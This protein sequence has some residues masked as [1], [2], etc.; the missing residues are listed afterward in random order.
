MIV[1]YFGTDETAA[2]RALKFNS[3]KQRYQFYRSLDDI[4]MNIIEQSLFIILSDM[5][6]CQEDFNILCQ[7]GVNPIRIKFF[8]NIEW[9]LG[10]SFLG[11]Y[12]WFGRTY[13]RSCVYRNGEY[14]NKDYSG[15][16]QKDFIEIKNCWEKTINR[17]RKKES[18]PCDG[19]FLLKEHLWPRNVELKSL[20]LYG[21]FKGESCNF[22]CIYCDATD[23]LKMAKSKNNITMLD[24]IEAFIDNA[25]KN[26]SVA[27]SAG[28]ITI[29]PYKNKIFRLLKRKNIRISIF[30][31]GYIFDQNIYDA[32]T[33]NNSINISLDSGTPE[34]FKMIKKIDGY[35]QVLENISRY[36][37]SGGK[38]ELK[39]I[40]L[41]G[42][43]DNEKDI[44]GFVSVCQQYASSVRISCNKFKYKKQL[45]EQSISLIKLIVD[46]C[47]KSSIPVS[48]SYSQFN[49]QDC[50]R[51]RDLL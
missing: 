49:Q 31:N 45:S 37:K 22:K 25:N 8:E 27:L 15:N 20:S 19:C 1:S 5:T 44:H 3:K 32:L 2:E 41:E 21:G 11:Q 38:I 16:I 33:H 17:W 51:L 34:T 7:Y 10:C 12:L 42:I 36:S 50:Y 6:H 48:F 29:S 14:L 47:Q 40:I 43:N 24:A 23:N 26:F 30:S 46:N 35:Y 13:Y 18:T 9:R 28:E 39:Y 4:S